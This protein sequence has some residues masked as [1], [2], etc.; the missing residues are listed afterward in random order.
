MNLDVFSKLMDTLLIASKE[1]ELSISGMLNIDNMFLKEQK[2]EEYKKT[3]SVCKVYQAEL[4]SKKKK[5]TPTHYVIKDGKVTP[6]LVANERVVEL[7]PKIEAEEEKMIDI[8]KGRSSEN[9]R[10]CRQVENEIAAGQ[11]EAKLQ[12][13]T[14]KEKS[15][16]GSE[17]KKKPDSLKVKRCFME[18]QKID[19]VNNYDLFPEVMLR[20]IFAFIDY[21][22]LDMPD[23]VPVKTAGHFAVVTYEVPATELNNIHSQM[24][25]KMLYDNINLRVIKPYKLV[26]NALISVVLRFGLDNFVTVTQSYYLEI[27]Q[28]HLGKL[29][30]QE[31]QV[32]T[33]AF[34]EW[35]Q[36]TL[37]A[38]KKKQ[39][40]VEFFENLYVRIN[41][42]W[43]IDII[44]RS[45]SFKRAKVD[46]T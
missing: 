18:M 35:C 6:L 24:G 36:L 10:E 1:Q 3:V 38:K 23:L 39:G 42:M 5:A 13:L 34:Y 16:I 37:K 44:E 31:L 14:L 11:N 25:V 26:Y 32:P 2:K 27:V 17:D 12:K 46:K 33:E 21:K 4:S 45:T 9:S 15:I 22:L 43:N 29:W 41:Q 20:A 19:S 8:D 30:K 40:V 7:F 28:H